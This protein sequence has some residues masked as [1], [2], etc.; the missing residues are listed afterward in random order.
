MTDIVQPPRT[1]RVRT[2][3]GWSDLAVMGPQGRVG[4]Q[5]E[6]GQGAQG[7]QGFQGNQGRQGAQG[8]QGNPGAQ[9]AQGAQGTQ[10]N[11][12]GPQ[13]AP[14]TQG[15]QGNQGTQGRQGFQGNQGNQGAASTVQG[16]QGAQG[17]QGTQGTQ[18]RQG[19]QGNQ[20][21]QGTGVPAGH[22]LLGIDGLQL[23]GPAPWLIRQS[24][25]PNLTQ[26]QSVGNHGV[27]LTGSGAGR[28]L[29]LKGQCLYLIHVY[30]DVNGN[31]DGIV[32]TPGV[33]GAT[34]TTMSPRFMIYWD[35]CPEDESPNATRWHKKV[36]HRSGALPAINTLGINV[37]SAHVRSES[38]FTRLTAF[39]SDGTP[40]EVITPAFH[41][42]KRAQRFYINKYRLSICLLADMSAVPGAAWAT[43]VPTMVGVPQE[44]AAAA[45][46]RRH[47][48]N[49]WM[50][51]RGH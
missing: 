50:R 30:F 27:T 9:G 21:N 12:Q 43:G 51:R 29:R 37:A 41:K 32:T 23:R 26:L 36:L 6:T 45:A 1:V 5:G 38:S 46:V 13:G 48:N 11:V 34:R 47:S 28:R 49:Q 24:L 35:H 39:T 7:A 10:S 22:L 15:A 16:P 33:D 44:H 40:G 19:F 2:A 17:T 4:P 18:G 8:A 20:G 3:D 14:G 31:G 42:P 25:V